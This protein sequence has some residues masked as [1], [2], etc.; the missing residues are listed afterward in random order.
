MIVPPSMTLSES[1]QGPSHLDARPFMIA[2]FDPGGD[3][4]WALGPACGV[5][6][7]RSGQ[8]HLKEGR[9]EGGGLRYLRLLR[10]LER[11]HE[12]TPLDLVAFERVA[13]HKGTDAAHVY[14]GMV[15]IITS[16][17]ESAGVPYAGIPVGEIK[18]HATRSGKADKDAVIA[19]MRARHLNPGSHDEADAQA[20]WLLAREELAPHGAALAAIA[21]SE[22]ERLSLREAKS[23][24]RSRERRPW[25]AA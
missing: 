16:W 12:D 17:C 24:S 5:N 1:S 9:F 19:A 23:R 10:W 21:R 14:G 15:A 4:G 11:I 2:A 22:L 25:P 7:L 8:L 6:P 20:I 18:K 13:A 3:L